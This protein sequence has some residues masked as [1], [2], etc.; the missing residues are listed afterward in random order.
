MKERGYLIATVQFSTDVIE[1]MLLFPVALN[2][3]TQRN[4]GE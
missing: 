3:T 2:D 1:V 4:T